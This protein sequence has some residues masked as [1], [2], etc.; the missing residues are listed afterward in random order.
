[1]Q[2]PTAASVTVATDTVQAAG[3]CELKPT[4][5]PDVAA[6]LTVKGKS[7][8]ARFGSVPKSIV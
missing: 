6:A 8:N 4:V 2:V 7:P 1:V 5:K 3:V